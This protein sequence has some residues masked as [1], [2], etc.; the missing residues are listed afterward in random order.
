MLGVLIIWELN[1]EHK[2]K[3]FSSMRTKC[4]WWPENRNDALRTKL[5]NG[6]V[7]KNSSD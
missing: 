3:C 7:K 4:G 6:F 2:Q 5:I 1:L